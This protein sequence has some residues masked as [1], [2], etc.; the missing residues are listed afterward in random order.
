MIE[1]GP[2]K[3]RA[4]KE[5]D[6]RME[7]LAASAQIAG[8]EHAGSAFPPPEPRSGKDDVRG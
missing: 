7:G 1:Q 2:R 3:N 4:A 8:N 6:L 5:P